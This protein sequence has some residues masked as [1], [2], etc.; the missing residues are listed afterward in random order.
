VANTQTTAVGVFKNRRDAQNAVEQLKSAGFRDDQIG[1]VYRDGPGK[2]VDEESGDSYAGEGAV[3][4]ALAGAGV[5][6][7]WAIGIAAGVLPAIGPVIAGGT[8]AAILASAAGG[9]AAGGILGSLLGL[10]IPEEEARFY[11]E[12]IHAGRTVVTV[13]AGGRHE[14]ALVILHRAG[15]SDYR[16][17]A[18][19]HSVLSR[20]GSGSREQ[21]KS[22]EGQRTVQ[23]LEEELR[24]EKHPVEKGEVRVR[25][26]V[27]TQ[28]KS[29]EVPVTREEIVVERHPVGTH[30]TATSAIGTGE[31]IRIPVREE[32]VHVVKEPVVKEEV[33]VGK[34]RVTGTERVEGT[35]KK[36]EIKIEEKGDIR[37]HDSGRERKH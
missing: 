37:V 35:V 25:K 17:S 10:G 30:K 29:I 12:E 16:S 31:E 13:R 3:T 14:E 27:H 7:L 2:D 21:K 28:H 8:L 15:A 26:E 22:V 24:A 34:R 5:G 18:A 9:A 33:R 6:G 36:E 20:K 23:A 19:S 1:V 11:E 32:E 4:G